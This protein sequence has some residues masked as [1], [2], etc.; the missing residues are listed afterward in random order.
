MKYYILCIIFGIILFIYMNNIDT[1]SISNQKLIAPTYQPADGWARKFY[2]MSN[3][4]CR[5]GLLMED[6]RVVNDGRGALFTEAIGKVRF[7]SFL[8]T[9]PS[10]LTGK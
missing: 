9:Y 10:N 4:K 2:L 5:L 3:N 6:E 8:F 7:D 1:F